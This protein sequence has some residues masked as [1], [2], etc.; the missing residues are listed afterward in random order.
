MQERAPVSPLIE[1][2]EVEVPELERDAD[3]VD[4]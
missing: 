3:D 1:E 4:D 2:P